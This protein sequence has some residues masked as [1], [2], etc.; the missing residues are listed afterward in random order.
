MNEDEN[1]ESNNKTSN[2][3]RPVLTEPIIIG[4]LTMPS[5]D[6][7][8]TVGAAGSASALPGDPLGY[9]VLIVNGT[10]V[11]LPYWAAS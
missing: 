7:Q 9:L 3:D 6:T 8:T 2:L 1:P 11:V 5:P 4:K 10:R